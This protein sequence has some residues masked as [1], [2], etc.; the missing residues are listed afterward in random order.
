MTVAFLYE[1]KAVPELVIGFD[2]VAFE[3]SYHVERLICPLLF[4]C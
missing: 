1:A 3:S 4:H 2:R